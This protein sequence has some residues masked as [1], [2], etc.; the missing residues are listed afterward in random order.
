MNAKVQPQTRYQP[1]QTRSQG[2]PANN[3]KKKKSK[4]LQA[5]KGYVIVI[6][7]LLAILSFYLSG[8]LDG[9]ANIVAAILT[10]TLIDLF[11]GIK[12]QRK[13][14]FSD[15]GFLT[16][17]IVALVL[18][19]TASLLAVIVTTAIAVL[20]KHLLKVKR[21]P[22]FNPAAFG[23]LAASFM[24]PSGQSWWG[25][26]SLLPAW[27]ISFVLIGG[28]LVTR[29]VNKFPQVFAF[30]GTYLIL[31]VGIALLHIENVAGLLRVP[32]INAAIFLA[33]FMLTDPPTSPGKNKDQ[34][35]F[36]ILTAAISVAVYWKFGGLSYL[37]IGLL[38][39]NAWK[40][41]KFRP[42]SKMISPT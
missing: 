15:G 5:P 25:G 10:G 28:F 12:Q 22:I 30:L 36:G 33:F 37:L 8:S 2:R 11:V 39:A 24:F 6:L 41:W 9:L 19:S 1:K 26:L 7:S 18:S 21:K 20:S 17:L 29:K 34:V 42:R 38:A 16:G 35:L 40:A 31:L 3:V 32:Y 14:L 23:L 13:K 27:A 4:F